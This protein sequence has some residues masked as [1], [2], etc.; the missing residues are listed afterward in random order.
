[1]TSSWYPVISF[2]L[3]GSYGGFQR[4]VRGREARLATHPK[5]HARVGNLGKSLSR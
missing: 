3:P 4:N 2:P 1:M 5:R